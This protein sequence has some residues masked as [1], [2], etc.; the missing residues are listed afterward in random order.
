MP[1][2]PPWPAFS[3][4]PHLPVVSELGIDDIEKEIKALAKEWQS[5][6]RHGLLLPSRVS[7]VDRRRVA[8]RLIAL[9]AEQNR[10]WDDDDEEHAFAEGEELSK[11]E[12]L[13]RVRGSLHRDVPFPERAKRSDIDMGFLVGGG[14]LHYD[15]DVGIGTGIFGW[16]GKWNRPYAGHGNDSICIPFHREGWCLT[17]VNVLLGW[18]H[19]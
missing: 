10:R 7:P 3:P 4:S 2:I 19:S 14:Y 12:R 17:S 6:C 9:H 11:E 18:V 15:Y 8:D 5:L 16:T 13:L 1:G